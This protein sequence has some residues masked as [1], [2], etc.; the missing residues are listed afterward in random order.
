[1]KDTKSCLS[2]GNILYIVI[3]SQYIDLQQR[4]GLQLESLSRSAAVILRRI[5]QNTFDKQLPFAVSDT[6]NCINI[7][8]KNI[9][10][11]YTHTHTHN[12]T[13]LVSPKTSFPLQPQQ[14]NFSNTRQTT[15]TIFQTI[16]KY[17]PAS[18][19]SAPTLFI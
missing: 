18:V 6:T 7:K 8:N 9:L 17:V 4:C 19:C 16:L 5:L 11:I 1:M 10:N 14:R 12:A 3:Q 2:S 15:T 13:C